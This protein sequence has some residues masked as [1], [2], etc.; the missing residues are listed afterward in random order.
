MVRRWV[1]L[2]LVTVGLLSGLTA[3]VWAGGDEREEK[4]T[5]DQVPA[6]AKAAIL[7][8][9]QGAQI[10]EIE[11]ETEHG[12]TVYEAEAVRNGKE[13]EIEVTADGVLLEREEEVDAKDV[14]EAVREAAKKKFGAN[15]A[16][17]EFEK[18][19]VILYEVEVKIG[20]KEHEILVSPTGK[21]VTDKDDED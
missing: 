2:G 21:I 12:V 6:A 1:L 4:V 5:I 8:E 18:K 11:Q 16:K 19:T 20:D 13:F 14:P 17:A 15:A 10:K 7:R 9:T 3:G